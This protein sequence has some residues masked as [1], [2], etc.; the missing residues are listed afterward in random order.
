[1][2]NLISNAFQYHDTN[3]PKNEVK[4]TVKT[5]KENAYF[6]V[7]DNGIGIPEN[8][9]SKIFDMFFRAN[10]HTKGTGLGLYIVRDALEKL[11]G[12][13]TMASEEKEYTCFCVVIPNLTPTK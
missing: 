7:W 6:E 9:Q 11:N 12:E 4:I 10:T 8:Y 3:K 1:L 2:Q 5:D 13:I